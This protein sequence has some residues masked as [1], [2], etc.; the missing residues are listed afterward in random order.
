MRDPKRQLL[1]CRDDLP[2]VAPCP[3]LRPLNETT[4]LFCNPLRDN[5][6]RC[7]TSHERVH[8]SCRVFEICDQAV[9]LSG[10]WN[11]A[12][13]LPRHVTNIRDV[14]GMLRGHGFKRKN[15]KVFFANGI[16]GGIAGE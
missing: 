6:K 10:G 3:R 8:T 9:L 7:E 16:D 5:T 14:Y 12:G 4:E 2:G 11:R 1:T 13:T 15:I